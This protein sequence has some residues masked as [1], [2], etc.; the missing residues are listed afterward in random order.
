MNLRRLILSEAGLLL[1]DILKCGQIE[2]DKR[3]R[4]GGGGVGGG[5]GDKI[6]RRRMRQLSSDF[7]LQ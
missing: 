2:E 4:G 7:R 6:K 1:H 3:E 5:G